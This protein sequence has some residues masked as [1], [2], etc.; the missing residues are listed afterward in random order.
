MDPQLRAL[1]AAVLQRTY[2]DL[3]S[4]PRG[5]G[6]DVS[7]KDYR[8]ARAFVETGWFDTL[9]ECLNLDAEE[10][11]RVFLASKAS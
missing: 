10:T 2:R 4:G 11:R 5:N 6:H 1:V 7:A 3:A 8:D 9:C